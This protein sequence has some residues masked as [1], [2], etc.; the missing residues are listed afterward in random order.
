MQL[1][2]MQFFQPP[3]TSSLF[4]PNILLNTLFPDTLSLCSS[5][6]VRDQ[7]I[8][9]CGGHRFFTLCTEIRNHECIKLSA[10]VDKVESCEYLKFAIGEGFITYLSVM[11]F[12]GYYIFMNI[13]VTMLEMNALWG[14]SRPC[15]HMYLR[16]FRSDIDEILHWEIYA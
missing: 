3:V 10:A 12:Y 6:N 13:F 16:N 2:I 9:W 8:S 11:S 7:V 5:L 14:R 4:G 1:H 15:V